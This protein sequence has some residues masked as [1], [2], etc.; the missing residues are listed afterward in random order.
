[1]NAMDQGN[2][3]GK[4]GETERRGGQLRKGQRGREGKL[5]VDVPETVETFLVRRFGPKIQT[6]L[7]RL[8]YPHL[9]ET[10]WAATMPA[11][12]TSGSPN[13]YLLL[14]LKRPGRQY[15]LHCDAWLSRENHFFDRAH[16]ALQSSHP[17]STHPGAKTASHM[18]DQVVTWGQTVW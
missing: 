18:G 9:F 1:M 5:S 12:G 14:Y 16:A 17:S 13:Y 10:P 11:V 4:R 8:Y 3:R 15:Q 7:L 2:A 6:L